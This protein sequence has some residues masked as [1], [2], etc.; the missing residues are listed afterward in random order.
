MSD[1]G[2]NAGGSDL[3]GDGGEGPEVLSRLLDA[4]S[5][6]RRRHA[7]YYLR[8]HELVDVDELAR[9]LATERPD[10]PA[11]TTAGDRIAEMETTVIHSDLPK[12]RDAGI[13]E[14]DPRTGTIRYRQSSRILRLLLRVCSEF[15]EPSVQSE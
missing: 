11:T 2:I 15:D 8:E 13:L 12:L 10:S 7:L 9:H 3:P 1:E 5:S 6:R 4:L 14:Y